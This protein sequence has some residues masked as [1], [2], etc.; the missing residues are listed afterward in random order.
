MFKSKKYVT[1]V[2]YPASVKIFYPADGH[3]TFFDNFGTTL[4]NYK[5]PQF[6]ID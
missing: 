4:P 1:I 6:H 5:V 2:A 3:S